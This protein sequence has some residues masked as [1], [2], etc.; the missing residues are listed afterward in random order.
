MDATVHHSGLVLPGLT[1]TEGITGSCPVA[2]D[3]SGC[4]A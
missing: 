1:G 3:G 2:A 4:L